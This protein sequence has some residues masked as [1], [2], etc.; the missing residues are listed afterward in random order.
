MILLQQSALRELERQHAT[1]RPPLMERAGRAAAQLALRRFGRCRVLVCA[2]PGNNG[3]DGFVMARELA[4]AGCRVSILFDHPADQLPPDARAA[5]ASCRSASADFCTDVPPGDYGLVVDALFGIGIGRPVTGRYAALIARINA[6]AGPVMALDVPSGLDADTGSV[7][8]LAVRADLTA[9]FI[10]AKPGLYTNEGPDHCGEIRVLDL[11]L[12]LPPGA[13]AILDSADFRSALHP[14]PRNS[15][16]GSHG[17]LAVLGGA[18]GMAGAAL[19]TSRAALMLGAGRVM[20]GMLERLP[21]DPLQPELMLRTPDDALAQGTAIVAGPGLGQSDAALALLRRVASADF[22]VLLDADALNLIAAHPV[23]AAR[24]ARRQAP[25]LLTPHPT[26]AARLLQTT[27]AAVQADRIGSACDLARRFNAVVALKGC[28]T[29]LARPDGRWRINTTGNPGLASAGTGDVLAGMTGALL[30][31]GMPA[32][33]ALCLA[34][35][36]HGA[37]ADTLVAAGDGP[38][39]LTAGELMSP[40]RRLLNRWIAEIA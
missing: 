4:R 13:G 34:V 25:T 29:V 16:K 31:Q 21:V 37:A 19:L 10:A 26:E 23:L 27:T 12:S 1:V 3:G 18:P 36:L 39:G 5:Y 32:W 14:R 35:H 28:G 24:I 22:S 2:G 20:V 7:H 11:G 30:A 38:T 8:G 6:F 17:T 40:A 9:S 33:E 15:H